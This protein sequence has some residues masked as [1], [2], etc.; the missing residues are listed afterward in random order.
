MEQI[1]K[2]QFPTASSHLKHEYCE[3]P[4]NANGIEND[5][6]FLRTLFGSL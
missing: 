6:N 3:K 2:A 4:K 1:G 5:L